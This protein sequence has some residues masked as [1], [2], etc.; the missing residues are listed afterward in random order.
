MIIFSVVFFVSLTA[1]QPVDL[2]ESDSLD[3]ELSA[4]E[5]RE[6]SVSFDTNPAFDD[7]SVLETRLI[8]SNTE[9]EVDEDQDRVSGEEFSLERSLNNDDFQQCNVFSGGKNYAEYVCTFDESQVNDENSIDYRLESSPLILPADYG[10]ELNLLA[11][12][13]SAPPIERENLTLNPGETE[14][15]DLESPQ[16]SVDVSIN[17]GVR[18]NAQVESHASVA[19][20]SPQDKNEFVSA[21]SVNINSTGEEVSDGEVRFEHSDDI[22]DVEVYLLENGD[23]SSDGI[24][25]VDRGD[26]FVTAEVPHFSTYAAYGE[27]E[28]DSGGGGTVVI[29]D[30]SDE[31]SQSEPEPENETVPAES[32]DGEDQENGQQEDT[33][34]P[35][36]DSG[37]EAE[38]SEQPETPGGPDNQPPGNALGQFVSSPTSV[39]AALVVMLSVIVAGLEYTG[40]TELGQRLPSR[41]E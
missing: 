29:D 13:S 6:F 28:D 14:V 32:S 22:T 4:G 27:E 26:D 38:D 23:W 1:A 16:G 41:A 25:I 37:G 30:S 21:V 35:P 12:P 2:T 8:V 11:N 40:R 34:G 7:E 17:S 33:Q 39:G 24:D 5:T 18:G 10:F 20:E 15:V 9:L 36:Q 31:D 19:A 3:F